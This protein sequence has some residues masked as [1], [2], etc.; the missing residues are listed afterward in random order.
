[1]KLLTV[2]VESPLSDVPPPSVGEQW[3]LVRLHR[4]PL[5]VLKFTRS[6]SASELSA[7]IAERFSPGILRHL[8]ADNLADGG[9]S[10][11]ARI[12]DECPRIDN[13]DLPALTAAVSTRN[14]ADRLAECLDALSALDYP[15]GRLD[16]LVV[17]NAPANDETRRL[18][19]R[20]SSLR[21]VVE[22][23]PG[24]DWAR[25]RAIAEARGEIIAYTDDDVS[26][27]P[28][29]A[30]AIGRLFKSDPAIE[31]VT[32][33][34][35]PDE[36]DAESQRLFEQYGGFGRG[37]DREYFRVDTAAGEKAARRHA[38]AGRFGT[39]ANMAFRRSIFDRIGTFD[40]AL[41]VGTPTNGGG[42]LEMFFRVLKEGGTLVYEPSATVRHRH[43]R[44]YPALRTQLENNGIGF[45]S[46]LVRSAEAY[47]DE[48]AGIIRLGAWWLYYWNLR[49]LGRSLIHP[50]E[51][52]R[53]L[54]LAELRGS[55]AGLRRYGRAKEQAAQV[56]ASFADASESVSASSGAHP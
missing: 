49:R 9:R 40:P 5:G 48:R 46:Y 23:R 55:F 4:E 11:L 13:T 10:S 30:A 41:D 16:L 19:D 35:V 14:G 54:I 42:D 47:P 20:Y 22:P 7:T 45:Y 56:A 17:D 36:M 8:A 25:N 52:P 3:V 2:E 53:D 37:F 43:R 33:L 31:A 28:G 38:G 21:Y 27:D 50:R 29:W 51:F 12:A 18:V 26:V 15:A 39:G 32:G 1:M 24:L 34:V 44:S 6:C